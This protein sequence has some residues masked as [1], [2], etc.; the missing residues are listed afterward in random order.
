MDRTIKGPKGIAED[1]EAVL[2]EKTKDAIKFQVFFLAGFC[3]YWLDSHFK[4][5]QGAD[6]SVKKSGF[7]SF[8]RAVRYYIM[9]THLDR[10]LDNWSTNRNFTG[11]AEIFAD[12]PVDYKERKMRSV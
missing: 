11:I 8:H 2:I 12:R 6:P 4:W 1:V 5:Y 9:I 10:L 3:K 7:L